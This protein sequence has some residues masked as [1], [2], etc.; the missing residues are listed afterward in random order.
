MSIIPNESCS[1]K[2]WVTGSSTGKTS[3]RVAQKINNN[4][5]QLF[6]TRTAWRLMLI[7]CTGHV[8]TNNSSL[9]SNAND[10]EDFCQQFLAG[11]LPF[12]S[13]GPLTVITHNFTDRHA[14][15]ITGR[16]ILF[17]K[18]SKLYRS[19]RVVL[20]QTCKMWINLTKGIINHYF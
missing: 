7:Y 19:N 13:S 9:L 4:L 6:Q 14:G 3:W 11:Q 2:K 16:R 12:A 20:L 8:V 5:V 1:A 10:H 18:V 17:L 15:S